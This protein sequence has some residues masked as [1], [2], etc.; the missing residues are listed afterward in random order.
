VTDIP[1]EVLDEE[2][3]LLVQQGK[4][5]LEQDQLHIDVSDDDNTGDRGEEEEEEEV[6]EVESVISRQSSV[7][8]RS[9]I[10]ENHDFV[11]LEY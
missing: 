8:D 5:P 1:Q 4:A 10:I 3:R 6:S 9:A 2:E 11:Q 7:V